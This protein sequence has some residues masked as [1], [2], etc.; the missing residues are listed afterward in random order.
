MVVS[1]SARI[2][3]AF[4][5]FALVLITG[6][7]LARRAQRVER[8][9]HSPPPTDGNIAAIFLA[10]NSTDISYAQVAL[11]PT[12]ATADPVI[13]FAKRMLSD[14][15]GLNQ[16]ATQLLGKTN[17]PAEDNS[18]SLNFRDES[19][20]KR[21]TLRE[22]H[23]AQFDSAYM[24]NEVRY[25]TRLLTVL[26]S[27]LIPSARNKDLKLL[28]TTVRPAVAAHLEHAQ[29]VQAGLGK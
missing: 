3:N 2:R 6:C 17:I 26:D 27:L 15:S 20:A 23:G 10:A 14:H 1:D 18:I 24:A 19:A 8:E 4:T 25:H 29:R 13:A 5:I 28:L 16:A 22:E 21:D 7:A 9:E 12:H 11:T